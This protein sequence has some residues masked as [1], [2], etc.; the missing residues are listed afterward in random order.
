MECWCANRPSRGWVGLED[1]HDLRVPMCL[2]GLAQLR[3]TPL[4]RSKTAPAVACL[5]IYCAKDLGPTNLQE[6]AQLSGD[7]SLGPQK[8][9]TLASAS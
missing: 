1:F 9:N 6:D 7:S 3:R 5:A 2:Q 4:R 8:V